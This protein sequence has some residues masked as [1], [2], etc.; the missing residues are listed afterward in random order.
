M[1]LQERGRAGRGLHPAGAG[2][3]AELRQDRAAARAA[4]ERRAGRAGP[5]ALARPAISRRSCASV[6]PAISPSTACA[7]RSS[8]SGSPTPSSTGAVRPW[9]CGWPT[10]R[11]A[12]SADVAYA[13]LAAREVFELPA[14]WAAHR[15]AR[16][17]GQG[18]CAARPLSGDA[19]ARERADACGSCA[20]ARRCPI[21]PAPSPGIAPGSPRCGPRLPTSCRAAA[22]PGSRARRAGSPRAAFPPTSPPISPRSMCWGWRRRSPRSPRRRARAVPQAARAI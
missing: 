11:A 5:R 15:C 20:M 3:A 18:R 22:R 4:G 12:R 14:L 9:R 13:F 8:R 10:R 19:G 2:G 16:R 1:E 6:S 21:S 17:P 7:A